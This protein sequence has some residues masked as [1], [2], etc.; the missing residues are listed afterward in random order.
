PAAGRGTPPPLD[1]SARL[2]RVQHSPRHSAKR[3]GH[4]YTVVQR[5][6][7]IAS[8]PELQHVADFVILVVGMDLWGYDRQAFAELAA[9]LQT[10]NNAAH[11]GMATPGGSRRST[12]HRQVDE[13]RLYCYTT[14]TCAE[15]PVP[16]KL[17][18]RWRLN[19]GVDGL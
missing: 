8:L 7:P 16:S 19:D 18:T 9:L 11:P 15:S 4:P 12:L 14:V 3:K 1:R 13:A 17:G 6:E 5:Q 2:P 10:R